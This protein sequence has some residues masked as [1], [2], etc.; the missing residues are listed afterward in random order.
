MSGNV[1]LKATVHEVRLAACC[2]P[3]ENHADDVPGDHEV[4]FAFAGA[5]YRGLCQECAQR[6][7]D[8][9]DL[10]ETWLFDLPSEVEP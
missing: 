8:L 9:W 1:A 5:P 2:D 6:V 3:W 7:A 4:R 10:R